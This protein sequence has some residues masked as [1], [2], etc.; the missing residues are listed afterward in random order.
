MSRIYD[1]SVP[2]RT[3][4]LVYPGNPEIEITL[5]QAVAK[6]AGANVSAIRFGSHTGTHADAAGISSTMANRWTRFHSTA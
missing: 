2:I 5:Q 4:G 6:G 1:I 3:G